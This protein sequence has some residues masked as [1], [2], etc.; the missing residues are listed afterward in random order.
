MSGCETLRSRVLAQ[1]G[2]EPR[3]ST[4]IALAAGVPARVASSQL[5]QLIREDDPRVL[6]R[7]A[8]GGREKWEYYSATVVD[9]EAAYRRRHKPDPFAPVFNQWLRATA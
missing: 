3:T 9:P 7:E 2:E 8:D 6:R 5:S 4:E 1:L